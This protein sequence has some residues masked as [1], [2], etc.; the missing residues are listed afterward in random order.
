MTDVH[1][2]RVAPTVPVC[3]MPTAVS[4]YTEKLGF[5]KVFENLYHIFTKVLHL[6]LIFVLFILGK[7]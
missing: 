4:F 7:I 3:D 5:E 6:L 2:G 1:F